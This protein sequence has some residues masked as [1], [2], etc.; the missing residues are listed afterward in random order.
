MKPG[1]ATRHPQYGDGTVVEVDTHRGI[2]VDFGYVAAWVALRDL[3][4]S[5]DIKS[6]LRST[7]DVPSPALIGTPQPTLSP[8]I[9]AARR[10]VLAL[11]LGQV[12]EDDVLQLS[13]GTND[14]QA[15]FERAIAAAVNR[16]PQNLLVEGAWGAGKTH[17]LTILTKLAAANGLATATVILDGEGITLSEPMGLMEAILGSLR[18][19][20]EEVP[21]GVGARLAALRRQHTFQSVQRSLGESMAQAIF[22]LP[23]S[24]FDEPEVREVLEDYFMLK[25]ASSRAREK[26]KQLGYTTWLPSL[27]AMRLD[28]RPQRFCDLLKEWAECCALTGAKGL[29]VV[30]DEVDV[31]YAMYFNNFRRYLLLKALG[32]LRQQRCPILLAF[33]SAPASDDMGDE[34][35]A[36][37]ELVESIEQMKRIEAPR[38]HIEL[39][40]ELGVRLQNLYAGAYPGQTSHLRRRRMLR[41]IE[42]FAEHHHDATLD[43]MPRGF[44]RGTLE[45]LDVAAD[46]DDN[47]DTPE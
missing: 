14:I 33:G 25:L 35:D 34:N 9:V 4:I 40:R 7:S 30:F 27:K 8:D 23:P 37:E 19:P 24:A 47:F 42:R 44:V 39:T 12:L 20:D 38:P 45:L 36:I 28:A 3:E 29:V 17:L 41:R 43:P 10:S 2:K 6:S 13:V 22:E 46:I 15:E 11:K 26:L 31:E 21:H 16:Y 1:I 32:S 5:G 18:Y